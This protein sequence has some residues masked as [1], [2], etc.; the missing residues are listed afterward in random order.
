MAGDQNTNLMYGGDRNFDAE[1]ERLNQQAKSGLDVLSGLNFRKL[2]VMDGDRVLDVGAGPEVALGHAVREMGASYLAYDLNAAFVDTQKK[3]G[4]EAIE[5]E[6]HD[7]PLLDG[8]VTV[9]HLR[10]ANAW[11]GGFRDSSWREIIRVGGSRLRGVSIDF[12]WK[13]VSGPLQFMSLAEA[14]KSGLEL[15]GFDHG[16]GSRAEGDINRILA[17]NVGDG[18]FRTEADR[19]PMRIASEEELMKFVTSTAR[20]V[21]QGLHVPM[22]SETP[23]QR[24]AKLEK[25]VEIEE[26]LTQV[27][28]GSLRPEDVTLPDIVSVRF[29]LQPQQQSEETKEDEA[30]PP[31]PPMSTVRLDSEREVV[32]LEPGWDQA[33]HPLGAK[34]VSTFHRKFRA[35]GHILAREALAWDRAS[36][37]LT[38]EA[39]EEMYDAKTL[40][41]RQYLAVV[42]NARGVI[43]AGARLLYPTEE[44]IV[45]TP[46]G[47][48]LVEKYG[49]EVFPEDFDGAVV[50]EIMATFGSNTAATE[51]AIL[52]CI[53]AAQKAKIDKVLYGAV[54]KTVERHLIDDMFGPIMHPF[55]VD[56]ETATV[57]VK[58]PAYKQPG[59][60][61]ATGYSNTGTFLLDMI[62][63]QRKRNTET[64]G[65]I[66]DYCERLD[67]L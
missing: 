3:A 43:I 22:D 33:R 41:A 56:G 50:G 28:A 52:R 44:G 53:K 4:N 66:I 55:K 34:T 64:A 62:Q 27:Q 36:G 46:T 45:S 31:F 12:D 59:I 42:L 37:E 39:Y 23:E 25:A 19:V 29:W 47:K 54:V 67:K 6:A 10:A 17:E 60:E 30:T 26:L 7:M 14:L 63:L 49:F 38:Q 65:V 15:V 51:A 21:I 24:Q 40:R 57:T 9:A 18:N 35:A 16:Y 11:F 2:G 20:N 13:V 61:L 58:G 32:L 5:G 8:S 1:R 48:K